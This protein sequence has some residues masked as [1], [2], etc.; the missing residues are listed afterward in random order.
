VMIF[1]FPFVERVDQN[2]SA[3]RHLHSVTNA[4]G[5]FDISA[6]WLDKTF[7]SAG[8][9]VAASVSLKVSPRLAHKVVLPESPGIT[10]QCL[11]RV[12]VVMS[13]IFL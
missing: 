1:L 6:K 7:A 13:V 5:D 3:R 11:V 9:S 10:K 2:S 12:S 8:N 4:S